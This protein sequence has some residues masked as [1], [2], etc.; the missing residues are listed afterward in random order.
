M[1]KKRGVLLFVIIILFGNYYVYSSDISISCRDNSTIVLQPRILAG[2]NIVSKKLFLSCNA[3][4]MVTD[5]AAVS[6]KMLNKNIEIIISGNKGAMVVKSDGLIKHLFEFKERVGRVVCLESNTGDLNFLN[7]GGG[8]GPVSLYSSKGELLWSYGLNGPSP[9]DMIADDIDG[10]GNLKFVIG[11]GKNIFMVNYKHEVVWEQPESNVWHIEI[12]DVDNDGKKEIVH[13]NAQGGLII[14]DKD[15]KSLRRLKLPIYF[16][17]FSLLNW[18][19]GK[20]KML[21]YLL[22]ENEKIYAV[23]SQTFKKIVQFDAPRAPSKFTRGTQV[24]FDSKQQPY[25][26][27]VVSAE[28][29]SNRSILYI[30]SHNGGL[31]Y[32]EVIAAFDPGLLT[33]RNKKTDTEKLLVGGNGMIWEYSL[34]E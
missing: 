3:V 23:N 27:A 18:S 29:S 32:N 22:A 7:R 5:I 13:S 28:A 31:V 1:V 11:T 17:D 15:G 9:Y 19:F 26:A 14:R 20:N 6:D 16:S 25:F 33:I 30:Y 34:K 12:L 8:W 24:L 2:E 21:T 4:G 10:D